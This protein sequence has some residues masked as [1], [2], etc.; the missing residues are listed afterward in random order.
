MDKQI[1]DLINSLDAA[2]KTGPKGGEYWMGRDLQQIL[3]Y[4]DWD[5]F[6]NV[7]EK[8]KVACAMSQVD[9]LDHFRESAKMVT[10]G[11]GAE[12]RI[13]DYFL[14]RYACYLI[15][16]N[17]DSSKSQISAAQTYFA[18][19]TRRQELQ[20]DQDALLNKRLELR[21]RVTVANK[22]LIQVAKQAGVQ[23]YALF[24]DAGY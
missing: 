6:E 13:R 16:M 7:L 20:D 17:G 10:I 24:H 11:S 23:K 22:A 5:K 19:Q 1:A 8:A 15:A 18:V 21:N 2:K 12:R 4:Q 9:V 3:G 14:T